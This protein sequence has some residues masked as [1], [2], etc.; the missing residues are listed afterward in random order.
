MLEFPSSEG[1]NVVHASTLFLRLCCVTSWR[2]SGGGSV[3]WKNVEQS[4]QAKLC[5]LGDTSCSLGKRKQLSASAE[6]RRNRRF[7]RVPSLI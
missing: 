5:M 7:D 3:T 2:G 6:K 1:G 4:K